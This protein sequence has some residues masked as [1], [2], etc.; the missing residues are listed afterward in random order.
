LKPSARS[1]AV[2]SGLQSSRRLVTN[3]QPRLLSCLRIKCAVAITPARLDIG[4]VAS[5][6]P[7][8]THTC[9][10][11]RHCHAATKTRPTLTCRAALGSPAEGL[12]CRR[13]AC[14]WLASFSSRATHFTFSR[15]ARAHGKHQVTKL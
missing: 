12:A 5:H 11:A 7:S 2:I 3:I 14:R 6:Y 15:S 13:L 1:K 10:N 4:L 9:Q 8:R